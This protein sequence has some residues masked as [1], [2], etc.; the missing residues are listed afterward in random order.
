MRNP[1]LIITLSATRLT[2][3]INVNNCLV[4]IL[5]NRAS[6]TAAREGTLHAYEMR[7]GR[8]QV[9]KSFLVVSPWEQTGVSLHPIVFTHAWRDKI[10]HGASDSV[11]R[12]Q[13]CVKACIV[14]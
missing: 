7:Q 14:C 3:L 13:L 6:L 9:S 2:L 4:N 8:G 12:M 1:T 11:T 5:L 10:R